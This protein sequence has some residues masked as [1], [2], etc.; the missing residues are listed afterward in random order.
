MAHIRD[1]IAQMA[2][3]WEKYRSYYKAD[4]QTTGYEELSLEELENRFMGTMQALQGGNSEYTDKQRLLENYETAMEKSL[5]A[6]DYKGISVKLL[7]ERQEKG[8]NYETSKEELIRRKNVISDKSSELKKIKE[9]VRGFVRKKTGWKVQCSM[10]EMRLSR[11]ME[12][13]N[14][15]ICSR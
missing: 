15:L 8:L 1:Q 12:C 5:Q 6:V 9:L 14:P 3:E 11:N 4:V 13:L 7:E 10:A 2:A